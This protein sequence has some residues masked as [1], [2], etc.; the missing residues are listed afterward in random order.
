MM[1]LPS[2]TKEE[3]YQT[4][5]FMKE[6]KPDYASFSVY[7]PFPGTE[8]F[9]I[10]LEKG[11]VQNERTLED[12]YNIS[13]KYYYVNDINRRVDTMD[14]KEFERLELKMKK[15]IHK[16]NMG[17]SRL[18][19]RAKARSNLYLHEPRMLRSDIKKLLAVWRS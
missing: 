16:Y 10:G 17:F 9:E 3:V 7:E 14:N 2:E 8:L 12:F 6:L 1:G 5:K 11:L 13:P 4:L 19:K 18:A 15:A